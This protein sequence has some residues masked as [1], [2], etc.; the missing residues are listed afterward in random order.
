M[1]HKTRQTQRPP[2]KRR[3]AEPRHEPLFNPTAVA[4]LVQA[5]V[6]ALAVVVVFIT[7]TDR[8]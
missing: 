3:A 6:A 8:R 5:A 7:A 2:A 1:A 4:T